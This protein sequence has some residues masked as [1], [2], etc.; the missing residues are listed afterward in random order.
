MRSD[1]TQLF[2]PL[3]NMIAEHT[4]NASELLRLLRDAV[5]CPEI[6]KLCESWWS[7]CEANLDALRV[8]GNA[9]IFSANTAMGNDGDAASVVALL[10]A[11]REE[12]QP[13]SSQQALALLRHDLSDICNAAWWGLRLANLNNVEPQLASL[14]GHS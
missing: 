10:L 6:V 8:A 9:G 7:R 3:E 12:P 5:L 13:E 4:A 1:L 2:Q 11:E 14:L